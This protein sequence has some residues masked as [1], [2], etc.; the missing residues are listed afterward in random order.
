MKGD[1]IT[2][3]R[4]IDEIA[5]KNENRASPL[6]TSFLLAL[7]G[8]KKGSEKLVAKL[9]SDLDESDRRA[10]SYHHLT[11]NVACIYAI[12]GN[13]HESMKWLRDSAERGNPSYTLFARDPFLDKIR[14]APEFIEFMAELKL[15]YDKYRSEFH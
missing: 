7:K 8:E 10:T 1:L 15:E 11:Y 9:I 12:N 2:A 13:V 5:A 6:S 4:R 3:K 14:Q